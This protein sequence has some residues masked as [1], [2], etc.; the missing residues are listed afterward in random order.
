M[1]HNI[2]EI[3]EIHKCNTMQRNARNTKCT[4]TT[5]HT[6]CLLVVLPLILHRCNCTCFSDFLQNSFSASAEPSDWLILKSKNPPI[7]LDKPH[8]KSVTKW[9]IFKKYNFRKYS[10]WQRWLP[11]LLWCLLRIDTDCLLDSSA[12]QT[13]L[14]FTFGHGHRVLNNLSDVQMFKYHLLFY[15]I[16]PTYVWKYLVISLK[17]VIPPAV[18]WHSDFYDQWN[19]V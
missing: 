2:Q 1:Q 14:L 11:Q 13:T 6:P 3:Q 4:Q 12:S 5:T 10:Y 7:H 18:L 8:I 16:L 9:H 15:S 19:V 17:L